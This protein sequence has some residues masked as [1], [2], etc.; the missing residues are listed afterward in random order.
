MQWVYFLSLVAVIGCL[1]LVDYRYRLAFFHDWRRT[2]VTLAVGVI[3]FSVWD[4]IGIKLGI[5]FSGQSPYM[6]GIYLL[7]EY[8]L[9]ELFFLFLLCFCTL[10]IALKVNL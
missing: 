3:V 1:L 9:E 6:S 10:L 5:F 7:P 8:P 4:I 2:S